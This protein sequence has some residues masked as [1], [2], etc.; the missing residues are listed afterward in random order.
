[1]ASGYSDY[2]PR[3]PK[4]LMALRV[5]SIGISIA[6][7]LVLASIG[8]SVYVDYQGVASE[9]HSAPSNLASGTVTQV[10]SSGVVSLNITI[11]NKGLYTLD[12]S[13]AC[14][15]VDSNVVCQQASVSVPPGQSDM[16]RFKMTIVNYTQF[17][18]SDSKVGGNV[19]IRLE[20]MAS[21]SIG[22]NLGS[23]IRQGSG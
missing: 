12:V 14:G 11:P 13:I 16:L 1:L 23:L 18:N 15:G 8:Y 4:G 10:G 3:K 6:V 5:A 9:L 21:L 19:S 2:K 22:V 20:P 7:I 17:L